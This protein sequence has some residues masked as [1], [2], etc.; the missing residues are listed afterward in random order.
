MGR[1]TRVIMRK[2]I[3]VIPVVI[4]CF[5]LTACDTNISNNQIGETLTLIDRELK[6]NYIEFTDV[7]DNW[8]G[9]ND[10]YWMP[11]PTDATGH[12]L[13]NAVSPKSEDDTICVISYTVKNISKQD[14][15][16]CDKGT[17]NFDNGYQYSDGGLSVRLT[18]DGV[19]SDIPNG[20]IMKKLKEKTYEFRVYMVVPKVLATDIEK[21]LTYTLFGEKFVLR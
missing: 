20:M 3:S 2:N 5:I 8:G 7:M 1:N 10:T 9:A 15:T 19:W 17:L 18:S 4:I 12:R 21:P 14:I 6:I 11:L 16:I 13:E